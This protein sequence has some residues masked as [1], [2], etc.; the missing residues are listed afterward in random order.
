M[1]GERDHDRERATYGDC[2]PWVD[3][4]SAVWQACSGA[5]L[6]FEPPFATSLQGSAL[7]RGEVGASVWSPL[8]HLLMFGLGW[9]RPDRGLAR[10]DRAG[11]SVDDPVLAVVRGWWGPHLDDLMAFLS[12]ASFGCEQLGR[13]FAEAAEPVGMRAFNAAPLPDAFERVRAT[14]RW[15]ENWGGGWDPMHLSGHV[16]SP[17]EQEGHLV[18]SELGRD[19][20]GVPRATARAASYTGWY[21]ALMRSSVPTRVGVHDVRVDV[22]CAPIGWLGSYRRSTVTGLW[23]RCS[24]ATHMLGN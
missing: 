19:M 11:R 14:E 22:L 5:H 13:R 24:H 12:G 20:E 4:L 9:S 7:G 6:A 18:V 1:S 16:L 2:G 10:W 8:M 17:V 23:F 3:H 21:R 15:R